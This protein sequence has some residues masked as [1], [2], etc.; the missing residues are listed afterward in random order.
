MAVLFWLGRYSLP[1]REREDQENGGLFF[2]GMISTLFP[3]GRALRDKVSFPF[4]SFQLDRGERSIFS[5]FVGL[6][7]RDRIRIVFSNYL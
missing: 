5:P 4:F 6:L 1:Q 7:E 2:V 3:G